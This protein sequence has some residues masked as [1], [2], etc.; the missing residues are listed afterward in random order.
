MRG[1]HGDP[2]AHGME[3]ASC[4]VSLVLRFY[5]E[6]IVSAKSS[7]ESVLWEACMG[8]ESLLLNLG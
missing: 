4:K 1:E 6:L 3:V 8:P 5:K 7:W 2:G